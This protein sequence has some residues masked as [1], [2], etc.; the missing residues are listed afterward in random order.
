MEL[1]FGVLLGCLS[2][3]LLCKW[4]AQKVKEE[5]QGGLSD[6][7][8]KVRKPKTLRGKRQLDI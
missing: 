2:Y 7:Q 5:I 6:K 8:A 1:L 3:T 4:L